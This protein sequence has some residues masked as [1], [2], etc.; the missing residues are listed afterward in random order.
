MAYWL[1][2]IGTSENPL[3]PVN[4]YAEN[5]VDSSAH[6][7]EWIGLGDKIILYATAHQVVFATADVISEP[8]DSGQ[9]RWPARV[10]IRYRQEVPIE[11]GVHVNRV[12]DAG[13]ELLQELQ[14]QSFVPISE[15]E[16]NRA[17][18]L[19]AAKA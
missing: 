18:T 15:G 19:V 9:A 12:R 13:H 6:G 3:D 16:F 14:H 11:R 7:D 17:E 2:L 4:G 8:Y 5:H 1:K 10:D